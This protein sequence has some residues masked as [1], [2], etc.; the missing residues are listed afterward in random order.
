[1]VTVSNT[2]RRWFQFRLF[3][4]TMPGF[5]EEEKRMLLNKSHISHEFFSYMCNHLDRLL[6]QV[7]TE[8]ELYDREKM[9]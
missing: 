3:S 6:D 5:V 4:D 7:A 2:R 8:D 1:M 9:H